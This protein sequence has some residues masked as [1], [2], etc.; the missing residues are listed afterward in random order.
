M[1]NLHLSLSL[2]SSLVRVSHW[3]S[4]G[5][6]FDPRL[7]L[8]NHFLRMKQLDERSS[9][10]QDISKLPHLQNSFINDINLVL[11]FTLLDWSVIF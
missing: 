2:G 9:V 5:C 6:G 4:E 3:S 11:Q 10:I 1:S 7:G 8:R